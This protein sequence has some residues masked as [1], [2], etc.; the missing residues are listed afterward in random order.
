MAGSRKWLVYTTDAGT[1]FAISLDESNTEAV[2][3]G[4][5]DFVAGLA[6]VNALPRNIKPRTITYSNAARTRSIKCV[7]LTQTIYNAAVNGSVSTITDPI[8]GGTLTLTRATGERIRVPF[9]VDTALDDG[10]AS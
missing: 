6:I 10:D 8:S 4:V 3:G 9:A 5:Q 2:N 1:N 7:A